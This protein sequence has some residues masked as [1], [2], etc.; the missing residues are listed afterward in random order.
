[1]DYIEI[2]GANEHNLKNLSLKIPKNKLVV[3]TGL[4]GSGKSSLAL[5]TIY[6][7]SQ[8]R[9]IETLSPY[10]R[11]FMG[12]LEKP[13]VERI[14]GLSP[15]VSIEQKTISNSKRST[16][17]TITEIYDYL[18]LLYSKVA[19]PHCYSCGDKLIKQRPDAILNYIVENLNDYNIHILA[20]IVRGKKGNFTELLD[21]L[22]KKGFYKARIDNEITLLDNPKKLDRYKAHDIDLFIDSI[23]VSKETIQ[24]IDTSLNIALNEG[25]GSVIIH[26]GIL[27]KYFSTKYTCIRCGISYPDFAPNNFSFNTH[28]GW[29][30]NCEGLGI[31]KEFSP[32]LVFANKNL[33]I[34]DGAILPIGKYE[35]SIFFNNLI[36]I[37]TNFGYDIDQPIS[38]YDPKFLDFLFWGRH[39]NYYPLFEDK[40][41][42][43]DFKPIYEYLLNYE[44]Y[45]ATSKAKEYLDNFKISLKCPVCGGGRL[46]KEALHFLFENYSIKDLVNIQISNL[47]P[48]FKD[49]YK[50][51][52]N[53]LVAEPILFEIK[54]RLQ[55]L[56]DVGLGYLTLDRSSDTLSGGESQ[57]IRLASQIGTQ[58][59]GVLYI[60]DEPSIGLH[61]SDNVKLINSLKKLVEMDNTVIV[62]EHDE[63]TMY[64]SDYIIELGPGA[65]INGGDICIHGETKKLLA[66]TQIKTPTLEVLRGNITI[67]KPERELKKDKFIKLYGA[68]GNNLKNVN[69]TIPLGNFICV[70]GISGSGKSSLINETL[71]KILKRKFYNSYDYPLP[72]E[73]I[74]GIENI[75]KIIE[76]DQSPIGRTP[77]SNPATYIGVFT[78]IRDLFA[79]LPESK[80]K[81]FKPGRFSFNVEGGRCPKC[82]G[83]GVVKI[84]MNYLPPVY[85]KCDLC[86]GKRFNKETLQIVYNQKN[87]A[88]ILEMT[89]EDAVEFF[90]NYPSIKRKL[91]A[92]CD[93]GLGYLTLGQSATTLSGGEAQRVKLATE[94]SRVST[95]KT[96]YVLDEP[97]T[98]LHYKDIMVL[99]NVL[100]QLVEKGNTVIVIE[101]NLEVIKFADWIIDMG[102]KGG[103][104][105]GYIIAEGTQETIKNTKNSLTGK[106]L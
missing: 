93:V 98:G 73:A 67:T 31:I 4:S 100:N 24:R 15:S 22:F 47:L 102:P 23:H 70:T 76:I 30:N 43:D 11:Q 80:A 82:E 64:N 17:G 20:P 60:L 40:A 58:L 28:Y 12:V 65:G 29:C 74:E 87:I 7:E 78:F 45:F 25:N 16:V 103:D 44:K 85:V 69:L 51:Y 72:Y 14:D 53:N 75:D 10:A 68:T 104:E 57:R 101:H 89:F 63:E 71:V 36:E 50:K 91:K 106:F 37:L 62:V 56:I 9:F 34:S 39:S 32:D 8:R 83:D 38:D 97:T 66:N 77:R 27:D 86:N 5:D 2:I 41:L 54:K 48:L 88:D 99:L 52:Q 18:R 42:D 92:V 3:V 55:F 105:G 61:P 49:F 33:S 21:K 90:S 6:A 59:T 94:L 81:G 84:E 1:M 79:Q 13:N 96:L 19:I 26:T 95:G 46:R 35:D